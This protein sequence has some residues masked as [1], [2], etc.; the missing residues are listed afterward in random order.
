MKALVVQKGLDWE[1]DS[2]GTSDWHEGEPPHHR[3]IKIAALHGEDISMQR[4]RPF[5]AQDMERFDHIYVMDS[6]N[7]QDVK[8]IAGNLWNAQKVDLILN[9]SKPG[10]NK[11]VP[12][13]WFENTDK[14]FE[15]VHELLEE[16]CAALIEQLQNS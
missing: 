2:A 6:Q 8:S 5:K 13:P 9:A 1:V 15:H 7:Y 16:A 14:A 12:D 4:S 10:K 11:A 3:S